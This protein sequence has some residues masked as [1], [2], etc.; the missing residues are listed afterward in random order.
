MKTRTVEQQIAR[1]ERQCKRGVIWPH[2]RDEAIHVLAC[3]RQQE[4]QQQ[5]EVPQ[6]SE[7][8]ELRISSAKHCPGCGVKI[9]RRSCFHWG[10]SDE[11]EEWC[12]RDRC[13][14]PRCNSPI[15][16]VITMHI[17]KGC[18]LCGQPLRPGLKRNVSYL[19][20]VPHQWQCS[21]W[22]PL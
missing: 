1:L 17:E 19:T 13:C 11:N 4:L 9:E 16:E 7:T 10:E 15:L 22:Y 18:K 2:E 21:D 20:V 3:P 14:C 12:N 8:V 5:L 6:T